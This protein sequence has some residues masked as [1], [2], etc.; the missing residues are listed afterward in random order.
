[1][2][3]Y[4]RA[5]GTFGGGNPRKTLGKIA[6]DNKIKYP[7]YKISQNLR[8]TCYFPIF[9]NN[10]WRFC[11]LR[12]CQNSSERPQ[13]LRTG[14]GRL[15]R[16]SPGLRGN[17]VKWC[18]KA[19]QLAVLAVGVYPAY[20]CED[21]PGRFTHHQRVKNARKWDDLPGDEDGSGQGR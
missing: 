1:M 7:I 6:I 9:L 15:L 16:R 19:R 11:V 12:R 2:R 10:S 4:R 3:S 8:T 18:G 17:Y 14:S 20:C 5:G 13:N 21:L